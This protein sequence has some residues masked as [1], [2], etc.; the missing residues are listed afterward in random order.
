MDTYLTESQ[1]PIGLVNAETNVIRSPLKS[2]LD[3]IQIRFDSVRYT[4]TE[5]AGK[6]RPAN[7]ECH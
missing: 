1:S 5:L 3:Q 4:G 7:N 2:E 6:K